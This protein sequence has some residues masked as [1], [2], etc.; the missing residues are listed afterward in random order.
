MHMNGNKGFTLIEIVVSLLLVVPALLGILSL[1]VYTMKTAETSRMVMTAMQDANAVVEQMRKLSEDG[2]SE[3]K[4]TYPDGTA[5]SGFSNLTGETIV[6]DY[7]DPEEDPLEVTVTVS[8]Q[9][10]ERDMSRQLT[11]YVTQR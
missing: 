5:V 3:V 8:W 2:L 7:V 11:T 4:A 9:D 1:T 10:R 6:V